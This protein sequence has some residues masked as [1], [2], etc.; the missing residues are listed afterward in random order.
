VLFG[1]TDQ[2]DRPLHPLRP[3]ESS[4]VTSNWGFR[5]AIEEWCQVLEG[6]R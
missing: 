2:R 1:R 3:D 5:S 4:H 6:P